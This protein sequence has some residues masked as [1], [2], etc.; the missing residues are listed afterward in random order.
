MRDRILTE[1]ESKVNVDFI[2]KEGNTLLHAFIS[3]VNPRTMKTSD[4]EETLQTI[5]NCSNASLQ[6]CNAHE[7][8]PLHAASRL[9][10][11]HIVTRLLRYLKKTHIIS[12]GSINDDESR[13]LLQKYIDVS[14][15]DGV[16][17]LTDLHLTY[18]KARNSMSP[19]ACHLEMDAFICIV[20]I[21]NALDGQLLPEHCKFR[22][23]RKDMEFATEEDKEY[24]T[25]EQ[26]TIA[27]TISPQRRKERTDDFSVQQNHVKRF[28]NLKP[29]ETTQTTNDSWVSEEA[30]P[31]RSSMNSRSWNLS[32]ALSQENHLAGFHPDGIMTA[33]STVPMRENHYTDERCNNPLHWQTPC[34]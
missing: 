13:K 26:D 5:L 30:L 1:W 14:N 31:P 4:V 12:P 3:F 7:E 32:S 28:R 20:I 21:V 17:L 11:P 10:L 2:D 6:I 15:K 18:W 33:I 25:S 16:A 34:F 29:A 22:E 9:G 24:P 27:S 19:D 23:F 8:T